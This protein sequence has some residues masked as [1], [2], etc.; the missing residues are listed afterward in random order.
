M[1]WSNQL[2]YEATDI[3]SWSLVGGKEPVRNECEVEYEIFQT[4][5]CGCGIKEA[6]I[7]TVMKA[8]N[9]IAYIEA[10]KK[11]GL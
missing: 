5:N 7:L 4:F 1:Q 9:A 8:I 11:S 2:S 3:G 6:M 10:C